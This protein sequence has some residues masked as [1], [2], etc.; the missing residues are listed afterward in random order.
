MSMN[1]DGVCF[2]NMVE[3]AVRNLN[4]HVKVVNQLNVFPVPDGDTGTNMVQTIHKGLMAVGVSIVDLPSVSRKFA[5]SV[6]F[7]ARGNSGVIVSQFLKGMSESFY[8]VD[9]V[10]AKLFVSALEKGVEYAYS[11][12]AIPVEGTM[13]TV[14]KD[15]TEAVK[16]ELADNQSVEDVINS[17][18]N[19]ARVSLDNTPELLPVLKETGVVD[20]GGAGIVF[21]FEGMKKYFDGESVDEVEGEK[22]KEASDRVDYDSFDRNSSFEFGYCTEL[23]LQLLNK[24]EPFDYAEFKKEL[25]KLGESIV[26][27]AENDKVRVHIHTH[28]PEKV[29]ALCH[30]Y[31]EFLSS[32]IENMTVQHTE[33]SKRIMC[34]DVKTNAAFAVVAVAQDTHIQKLFIDMGADVVICCDDNVSTK[35]YLDAFSKSNAEHIFVFPNSSDAILSAMQAKKLYQDARVTVVN[36][37]TIAECYAALPTI[38]FES[39]DIEEITDYITEV[40]NNVY[41]ASI[42]QRNTSIRYKERDICRN[43]YYSFSGKELISISQ[44]FKETAVQTIKEILN[45]KDKEI[46]T[47]FH[48]SNIEQDVEEVVEL[49]RENG[50]CAEFFFVPTDSLPCLMTISFE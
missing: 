3:Y 45:K 50:V 8:D 23:L 38:D 46:V 36:S 31:G 12:V 33:L 24:K 17:F 40:V 32:K 25:F 1:M 6:V 28:Y 37:R 5:R 27:S 30:R 16:R 13:L 4:K 15:A 7:E 44:D 20:S 49:A 11:S 2:K 14:I 34:S 39:T 48:H 35:D 47:I 18:V 41:V 26:V 10:D 43:E 22:E 9:V 29:F 19:H 42:S 21:L